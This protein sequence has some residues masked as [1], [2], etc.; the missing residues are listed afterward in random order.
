MAKY[1]EREGNSCHIHLSLRVDDDEPAMP[2]DGT[3]GLLAADGALPRRPAGL[4]ARSSRSSS[5]RT[6]TPTSASST[7][8]SPPPRWRGAATTAPARCGSSGHGQSLRVENRVPGGDV[9]PYLAV[10]A[11]IAAG[12]HG[13]EQ[14]AGARAGA[15]GNAYDSDKPHVPADAARRRRR[16]RRQRGGR[17]PRSATT[18]STTTSTP[19]GS[20]SP[21]STPPSPTGSGSVASSA[22]ETLHR[23]RIGL[24]TYVEQARWGA[25]DQAGRAA[26]RTPYVGRRCRPAGCRC[27][28]PRC[29]T[30]PPRRVAGSTA[31]C[32][33][34]APTSTRRATAPA[35]RRQR[36]ARGATATRGSSPCSPRRSRAACRCS[37][38]AAAPQVLNVALGG[39]LHQHLPDVVGPRG[40]PARAR[41]VRPTSRCAVEPGLAAGRGRRRARSTCPATT[42]RPSTASATASRS[43]P[44]PT[45]APS[46]PSSSP[47]RRFVARRAV[48]PR[49][50]GDDDRPV[51]RARAGG[52]APPARHRRRI[53]VTATTTL[54]NPA[55]E[56]VVPRSRARRPR[57]PTPPS[58]APPPRC[59]RGAA[60]A[61]GDRARLLRR[62]AEA[63]DADLEHLAAARGGQRRPHHRQRPVG[64][65]Q[66]PRRPA[67]LRRPRRSGCSAGRSRSPA[68]STSPSASRS[69]SSASSCRGTSRCRSPAGGSRRR[70]RR[71]TASCS[72]RPSSPR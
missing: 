27:C 44:G 29:R 23:P 56:E 57:R 9:N 24:P 5:R 60:V 10:A 7:A 22:S 55:T 19:A 59:R 52:S 47:G 15:Q 58:P 25:W 71:A 42:T 50:G 45:T 35:P 61:P 48:A 12:L 51:R 3:D 43:R 6:S 28:C 53:R 11:L 38:S 67:V 30:A 16:C 68:A 39:S 8:A 26:A 62:F 49:G 54:V 36:P 17:A 32:S 31:C 21:P 46:R 13:I 18:S 66:R 64:G 4:P 2:G 63:V 37:P 41:H 40:A 14:R 65:G 33:P 1:D 34:A 69:A 20:S 70:S 72:S